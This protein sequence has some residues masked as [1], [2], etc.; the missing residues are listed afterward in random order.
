MICT[1][2]SSISWRMSTAGQSRPTTCS[3][4]RSPAPMP[5]VN[6]PS[7]S[8]DTVAAFWATITGW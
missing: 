3:L 6:R 2:S 5:R 1:A 8:T 4:S 7:D